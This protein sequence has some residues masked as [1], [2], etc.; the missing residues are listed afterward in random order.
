MIAPLF[1]WVIFSTQNIFFHGGSA[2]TARNRKINA[3]VAGILC[4]CNA[5]VMPD[6]CS[7]RPMARDRPRC[8]G[9]SQRTLRQIV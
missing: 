3:P 4:R 8:R 6:R 1:K 7:V 9:A 2:V 5:A